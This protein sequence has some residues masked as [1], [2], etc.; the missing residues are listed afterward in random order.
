MRSAHARRAKDGRKI[1]VKDRG[2]EIEAT[3]LT[4]EQF[5]S[6]LN[7]ITSRTNADIEVGVP[8]PLKERES[9]L[10]KAGFDVRQADTLERMRELAQL[11]ARGDSR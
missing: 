6:L 2:L 4:S 9:E 3:Q 7:A 1:R 10:G 5:V 11:N 8:T